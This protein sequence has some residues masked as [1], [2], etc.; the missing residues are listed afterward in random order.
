MS[1]KKQTRGKCAY[2]GR[3]F[4]KGGMVKHLLTCPQR[5]AVIAASEQQPL[6]KEMLYHLRVQDIQQGD[7]WLDLE[8]RGSATLQQLDQYLRAIWLEC[9]GHLSQF[10]IGS[11]RGSEI[12][13]RRRIDQVFEPGIE[14]T[15]IYDFG[16]SSE[17]LIKCCIR[18]G[19]QTHHPT[20]YCAYGS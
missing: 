1:R 6:E 2:C 8:M 16:T 3:E 12:P 9:C 7:F 17:T 10:S 5:Q 13:K 20:P 19:G 14:L 15:H 11:W 18:P 4:A